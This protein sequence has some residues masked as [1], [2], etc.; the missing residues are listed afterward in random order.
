MA[1]SATTILH[2]AVAALALVGSL[3]APALAQ[4]NSQASNPRN[5]AM[6]YVNAYGQVDASNDHRAATAHQ[7]FERVRAAADQN[8]NRPPKLIIVDSPNG[9]PWAIALP[10]GHIILSTRALD[11]CFASPPQAQACLAFVLGHELA[12]LSRDDFLHQEIH[13]F[14]SSKRKSFKHRLNEARE[15]EAAADDRGYVY[16]AMAGYPVARLLSA[17][18]GGQFAQAWFT[19]WMKQSNARLA[20][21]NSGA[22]ERGRVLER[23]LRKID[24]ARTYFDYGVRLSHFD[25]CEDA[26]WFFREFLKVLPAREVQNNLGECHL[27]LARQRM[28]ADV[29]YL[30]WL[31]TVIDAQSRAATMNTRGSSTAERPSLTAFADKHD[32]RVQDHLAQAME[33]LQS[34]ERSDRNYL[35]AKINL[36]ITHLYLGEPHAATAVLKKAARIAPNDPTVTMLRAI[37]LNEQ[38]DDELD[39][40]P[41]ALK[42]MHALA[43]N[44]ISRETHPVSLAITYNLAQL[45]A[46]RGPGYR[47]KQI[48]QAL[49]KRLDHLPSPIAQQVCRDIENMHRCTGQA[50]STSAIPW[51]MPLN[52]S[53]LE[54]VTPRDIK[55]K[56]KDWREERFDWFKG[57]LRGSIFI[58]PQRDGSIL[59]LDRFVQMQVISR[60]EPALASASQL[61]ARCNDHLHQREIPAGT[62]WTCGQWAA[63]T[64]AEKVVEVWQMAN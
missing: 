17:K 48:W 14:L 1:V 28:P 18:P 5:H 2:R 46:M 12:H 32:P 57:R 55:S 62:L 25:Y 53:T 8:R 64:R 10:D 44:T 3:V 47:N 41:N 35:P 61:R 4:L 19:H 39:L 6:F 63:L 11:I 33:Y 52:V 22:V 60:I 31:P 37:A 7:V 58:S 24:R 43:R 38:S 49:A 59:V 40:L 9:D 26:I 29:A 54:S 36:A 51:R 34:A 15:R 42:R 27:K 13:H 21:A 56:L 23:R 45:S 50:K 20:R 30:Y 16:A